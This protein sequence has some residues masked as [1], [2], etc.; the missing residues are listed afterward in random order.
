MIQQQ[1]GIFEGSNHN[2]LLRRRRGI[3]GFLV[4]NTEKLTRKIKL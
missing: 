4:A 1:I 3:Y 2:L